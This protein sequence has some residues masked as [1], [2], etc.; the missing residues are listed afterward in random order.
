[1]GHHK[2]ADMWIPPGGHIDKGETPEQTVRREWKE[3]LGRELKNEKIVLFDISIIPI[4][5]PNQSCVQHF[6][7]WQLVLCNRDNFNFDKREFYDA[8][9]LSTEE[10][11]IHIAKRPEYIL[12][13]QHLRKNSDDIIST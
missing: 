11:L 3:E 10:A 5:N 13:M 9:W 4:E 2:K 8:R 12:P 6:D 7:F 1:M